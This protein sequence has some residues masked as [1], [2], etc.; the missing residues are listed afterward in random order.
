MIVIPFSSVY[1]L[2]DF[3]SMELI[4]NLLINFPIPYSKSLEVISVT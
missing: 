4:L 3:G 2:V 1:A